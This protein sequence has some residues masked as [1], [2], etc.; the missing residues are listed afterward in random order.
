MN[1]SPAAT[2]S[3][4]RPID[5]GPDTADDAAWSAAARAGLL[6]NDARLE[7]R[8]DH[9]DG[10][11]RVLALRARGVDHVV[12]DGWKR[13]VPDSLM[14][15]FAVGGYGR[16][17]LFPQSDVDLLVLAEPA[18]QQRYHDALARFFALLWDA[19]LPISHAVRSVEECTAAAHDQT[20]LT[21]IIEARPLVA[22]PLDEARLIESVS[23]ARA[24]P[25]RDF[26]DA[27]REEMRQRHARF[28]DTSENLEPNIKEG[29]GG[30][31]DLHALGWMALR[32]FGVRDLEPLVGMG[33]LG[34]DEAAAL[35]RERRALGRLRYGLHLIAG[36]AEERLRFDYQ[37]TL[38]QRLGFADDEENLGVE[39][40]M[41][42]FYRSAAIVRRI[43]DRLLQR[44]EEQFD[45]EALPEP[46]DDQFSLR[47]GYLAARDPAWPRDDVSQVFALFAMWAAQPQA[48]GLHSR[49]ARALAE[50]LPKLTGYPD[51]SEAQRAAFMALLRGPRA[52][53]TLTRMARLGVLGQWLPAFARVSGRMQFDLFHVYTVDQHTLMVLKNIATFAAGRADE[54]FSIA[55]EVWPRLRKPELLLLAGLFHDIAKGR[56]G[57][58]SELGAVDAREFGVAHGLSDADNDLVAWLVEQHLRMSVTAQKQDIADPDVIHAFATL[59]GDRERLDYL[60]LLTCADIAGTSPK[61]WNAWKDRLLADLYFAARR[62]LREGLENPIAVDARLAEA[63]ESVRVMLKLHAMDDASADALFAAMPEESFLRFR[64]EQLAWQAEAIRGVAAGETRVRARLIAEDAKA[65]EVFVHSPDR[66]GLFAAILA[67]LDRMGFAIHQARVLV[68]PNGTVFD[69]FEVLPADSYASG[70]PAEVEQRLTAAL[71]GPLDK[72]RTSRRALPRQLKH[73]RF[74]PRIE[75]G[76]T[77]DGRRTVL[78]LI[79]PDRPGLLSDVA[80]VLRA[81]RLRVHD[82]RIATFGERAEDIFQISDERD[83][84]LA[85]EQQE[86]ALRDAIRAGLENTH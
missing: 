76:R 20:V 41:Q 67:T 37:K 79:A 32:T 51:A 23:P 24:W 33:H 43:G 81:Q 13:C 17:E 15:L 47:R 27:K 78:S 55:H 70:D 59:V 52:V 75:F 66:D 18:Q 39:K 44:F 57:D 61:L 71:A 85:S 56:G 11:D 35:A 83:M 73:F 10:M 22:E 64:P 1:T 21:A 77:P 68:G 16:G 69:T 12:R 53:E 86:E 65:M 30:L 2:D 42:G 45:G 3:E 72:V 58:H 48:R 5:I 31:R 74:A 29:P 60:Y 80:Q 4:T 82:A 9:G 25:A 63:R 8:F 34:P 7:K 49:T 36:R 40:M 38:A 26:F 19:G 84:P 54:R 50:A 46:L 62:V 14:A 6:H 28:G